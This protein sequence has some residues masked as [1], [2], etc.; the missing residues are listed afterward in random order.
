MIDIFGGTE[1]PDGS[2]SFAGDVIDS[3][4]LGR[5]TLNGEA[6]DDILIG[7]GGNDLLYGGTG[8]D[9]LSG[10]AN[11]DKL[12]GGDGNDLLFGGLGSDALFGRGGRDVL[13][14]GAGGDQLLGGSSADLL[15]A[16]DI[17]EFFAEDF[18]QLQELW[19]AWRTGQSENAAEMLESNA[20][21]DETGDSLHGE[22][23]SDWYITFQF[24]A[25]KVATEK[26][27]GN[28]WRPQ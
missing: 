6:G 12:D 23:D 24:D 7:G 28:V 11:T 9:Y 14:G 13:I 4:D 2:I 21:D 17:D 10:G 19:V 15:Y 26:K 5:D 16:G 18:D 20:I 25:F 22:G 8:H 1:L 27:N 3:G